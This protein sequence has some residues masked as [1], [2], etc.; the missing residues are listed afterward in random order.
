MKK[1]VLLMVASLALGGCVAYPGVVAEPMIIAP[2]PI[3]VP[4]VPFYGGW[5]HGHYGHRGRW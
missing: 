5:H 1:T 3:I 4:I 2:A